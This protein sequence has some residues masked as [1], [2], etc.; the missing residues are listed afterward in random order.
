M[1]F[2]S[3]KV[4]LR[5]EGLAVLMVACTLYAYLSFSWLTFAIFFFAPDLSMLGFFVSKKFGDDQ[6]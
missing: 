3:P 5:G 2:F 1:K 6:L 4:L